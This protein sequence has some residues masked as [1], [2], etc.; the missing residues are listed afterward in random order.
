M[1]VFARELRRN[2]R[3]WLVWAGILVVVIFGV[4]SAYPGV[5]ATHAQLE[6]LLSRLPRELLVAFGIDRVD[7][8][9]VLGYYSVKG[10]VVILLASSVYAVQLAAGLVAKEETDKTIE[11]LLSRPISRRSII[12][13]KVAAA[14]LLVVALNLVVALAGLGGLG[15]V[16]AVYSL[17]EFWLLTAGG[18]LVN[19]TFAAI[20]LVLAVFVTRP[21]VLYP[22]GAG[23]VLFAYM[24]GVMAKLTPKLSGLGWLSPFNYADPPEILATQAI[25]GGSLTLFAVLIIG[26][27][28]AAF[29]LYDRKDITI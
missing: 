23:L 7:L 14:G 17:R 12:A 21:R 1:L 6:Q 16:K 28:V 5:S 27:T 3:P 25:G 10:L 4:M 18:L 19:L 9:G 29:A 11:F 22:A 26:L 15:F 20:G 24:V 2:L 8:A 13:G